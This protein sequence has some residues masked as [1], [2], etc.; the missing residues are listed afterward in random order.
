VLASD[1]RTF[2]AHR[3]KCQSVQPTVGLTSLR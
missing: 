3:L 2:V 1:P